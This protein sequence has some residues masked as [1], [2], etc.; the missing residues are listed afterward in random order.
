[1]KTI[2]DNDTELG[3]LILNVLEEKYACAEEIIIKL[4]KK[5]IEFN[6]RKLYPALSGLLLRKMLCC[7]WL[8]NDNGLPVKHYHL[9][10]SGLYHIHK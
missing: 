7:N 5:K 6:E 4:K 3:Y 10:R 8:E 1:M 9:T 2:N